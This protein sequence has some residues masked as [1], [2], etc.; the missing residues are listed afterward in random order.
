[1][2][3]VQSVSYFRYAFPAWA[4]LAAAMGV[5]LSTA[6]SDR[7]FIKYCWYA[8]VVVAVGLNLLFLNAGAQYGD[9]ALKSIGGEINREHYLRDR[10]P[11]RNAVELVNHLNVGRTP[12]A[13]FS[14]P[15]TAGLSA[16]ALYSNWYNFVFQG[17]ITSIQTELDAADV[18]LKRKVDFVILDSNWNGGEKKQDLIKSVTEKIAEYGS[19]SVRKI[20]TDFRFKAELLVNPEFKSIDGW[21]LTPGAKYEVD[22][23]VVLASVAFPVAQVVAVS[24]GRRYLN[25]VVARCAKE[26]T[27][28][29]VQ[30]N[31]IDAKGQFVSTDIKTFECS[32]V[33]TEHTME[34][35]VPSNAVN[36]VV[37]T[38]GH[39]S[40]PLEFKSNS[41][42]K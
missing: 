25:A 35:S 5:A 1:M 15:M 11:I 18:L 13:V 21:S 17:E 6:L 22:T 31:W 16:D 2:S 9:F 7:S 33:W 39:T 36:A 41:L 27:L 19:I 23:G 8:V 37:Y 14:A 38:T 32:P 20:K 12:V 30:I 40:I 3:S 10:L 34:V 26:P 29:R 42:R 24:P 4:I 28:G